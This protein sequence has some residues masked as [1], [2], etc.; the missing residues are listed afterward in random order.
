A[1][2]GRMLYALTYNI[3]YLPHRS[4]RSSLLAYIA[5]IPVRIGFSDAPGAFLYSKR[6]P[7]TGSRE[8]DRLA[9]LAGAESVSLRPTMELTEG[10][11]SAALSRL[12]AHGIA[13][14]EGYVVIA[15]GATWSTKIWPYYRELVAVLWARGIRT[16]IV[17]DEGAGVQ[18]VTDG[19][20]DLCG[21]TSVRELAATIER[22]RLAVTNDSGPLHLANAVA[23]PVLA[24][25]GPTAPHLGFA[26]LGEHDRV[27][28]VQDLPCRPCSDHGPQRC[29]L[30]HHRCMVD[31]EPRRVAA[32]ALEM[33]R[34]TSDR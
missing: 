18:A 15:P 9:A 21:T 3:A 31:L 29:P 19:A 28:E 22:A 12:R 10:D 34:T 23:T 1:A 30:G 27:A 13:P 6:I 14:E 25:F 7:R 32:T 24:I 8:I 11:R 33:L 20:V 17:G 4:W 16:V 26:P 2:F 5:R